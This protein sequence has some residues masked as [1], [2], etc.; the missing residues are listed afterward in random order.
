M[1]DSS[2]LLGLVDA[3]RDK[4]TR[5]DTEP[6]AVGAKDGTCEGWGVGDRDG[7]GL[8]SCDGTQVGC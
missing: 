7:R 2:A 5:A 6:A 8:G 3:V 1:I 4:E